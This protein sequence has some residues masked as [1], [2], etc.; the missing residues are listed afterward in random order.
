MSIDE[1]FF[2]VLC[3]GE[4]YMDFVATEPTKQLEYAESFRIQMGGGCANLAVYVGKL[5]GNSMLAAKVG[6][7]FLGRFLVRDLGNNEVN[8]D[9]VYFHPDA[10]TSL[11]FHAKYGDDQDLEV[12]RSSDYRLKPGDIDTGMIENTRIVHSSAFA[13]SLEPCRSA[14]KKSFHLASKMKKIVSFDPEHPVKTWPYRDEALAEIRDIYQYVTVTKVSQSTA[15]ELFGSGF[16]PAE[17]ARK[18]HDLGPETVVLDM[19]NEGWLVTRGDQFIEHVEKRPVVSADTRNADDAFWA[20]FLVAM[21]DDNHPVTSAYFAR[22]VREMK[23]KTPGRIQG[24]IN[25][26]DIYE[27]LPHE[28]RL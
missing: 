28:V 20:G 15:A 6:E 12:Y 13:L 21:L 23:L 24:S 4:T 19:G 5:W 27:K 7:D 9:H 22:E 11:V 8:I 17:Y 16:E 18:I 25:R 26:R 1:S 10:A 2:D 3:I 14:V